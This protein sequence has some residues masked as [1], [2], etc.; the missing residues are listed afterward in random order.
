[1]SVGFGIGRNEVVT[2]KTIDNLRKK[3]RRSRKIIES[4]IGMIAAPFDVFEALAQGFIA[5][6]SKKVRRDIIQMLGKLIPNP[7]IERVGFLALHHRLLHRIA[8]RF[9]VHRRHSEPNHGEIGR[10]QFGAG[11]IV[12]RRNQFAFGEV[13]RRPEDN[14]RT[15]FFGR[16][17][18]RTGFQRSQIQRL[19]D[20]GG[21]HFR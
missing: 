7:R 19:G 3:R 4:I 2:A 12:E 8:E 16:V 20:I 1:M 15:A 11:E 18:H 10:Q 17:E 14:K 5:V 21:W 13:S 6:R 9:V